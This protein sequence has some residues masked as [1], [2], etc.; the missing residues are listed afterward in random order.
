MEPD[1]IDRMAAQW[2]REWPELDVSPS[3]VVARLRRVARLLER[4]VEQTTERFQLGDGGFAVL[5]ALRRS[6]PPHQ[7]SPT[8]ISTVLQ[9]SSGAMTYQLS[10]LEKAGLLARTP[11][12]DDRRGIVVS[13]T[14]AGR[15]L[16]DRA[17]PAYFACEEQAL[18][19]LTP[20]EREA[21]AQLLKKL[22]LG[23]ER[24]GT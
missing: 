24:N 16:I 8:E 3:A 21:L 7:L 6:G 11:D 17:L 5:A 18:R 13:L 2:A 9:L 12:K 4:R 19:S 14:P 23:L 20:A 10:R 15:R 1:A 22:L